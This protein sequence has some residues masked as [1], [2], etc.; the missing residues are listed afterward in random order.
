M[1]P[2]WRQHFRGRGRPRH[3]LQI[4]ASI[5]PPGKKRSR[6]EI[7]RGLVGDDGGE[8]PGAVSGSG[9]RLRFITAVEAVR[10]SVTFS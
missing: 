4:R 2:Y 3:M 7:S 10:L 6:L 9:L 8:G 1:R 5:K